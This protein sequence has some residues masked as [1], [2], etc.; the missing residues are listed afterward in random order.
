MQIECPYCEHPVEAPAGRTAIVC[1]GCGRRFV[2]CADP[3][4]PDRD[5]VRDADLS[6]APTLSRPQVQFTCPRCDREMSLPAGG[7]YGN[8]PNCGT[9]LDEKPPDA[10]PTIVTEPDA[11]PTVQTPRAAGGP[12][13]AEGRPSHPRGDEEEPERACEHDVEWLREHLGGRYEIVEFLARGGMGAVYRARQKRPRRDVALKM[14]AGGS[15]ASPRQRKRFEREA[16]AVAQLHH[17]A[18]VP[19]YEYGEIA[20]HPYFTMEYVEGVNLRDYVRRLKPDPKEICRLMVEVCEAIHYAHECGVIHRDLKP[21]NIIVEPSG[22]PRVLDFGLSRSSVRGEQSLLTATGDF[23]GTP[24]YMS[25][26]QAL[27]QPSKVDR[28]SDVYALGIILYELLTGM[29]PYPVDHVQGLEVYQL[30][31]EADPIPPRDVNPNMPRDLEVIILTAIAKEK[32]RRYR[33]VRAL[34]RDLERFLEDRP[35]LARPATWWY[36]LRKWAWRNRAALTPVAISAFVLAAVATVLLYQ[37]ASESRRADRLMKHY[38]RIM[39]GASNTREKVGQLIAEDKWDEARWLGRFAAEIMPHEAGVEGLAWRVRRAAEQ[40]MQQALAEFTHLLSR[41]RWR[42]AREKARELT[43]LAETISAYPELA[44]RL[45]RVEPEFDRRC[46]EYLRETVEQAY[47]QEPADRALRSFIEQLPGN[48][49]VESARQLLERLRSRQPQYFFEQHAAAFRRAMDACR[50][51]EA[52]AVCVSGERF[53]EAEDLSSPQLARATVRAWRRELASVIRPATARALAPLQSARS[54]TTP[55]KDIAVA[56]QGLSFVV[57]RIDRPLEL[58]SLRD[59]AS[60]ATLS[61]PARARRVAVSPAGDLLAAYLENG[62]IPL[63]S[64]PSRKKLG[65]LRGHASRVPSLAFSSDGTLLL[66]ADSRQ[67]TLW[68]V[69]AGKRLEEQP[70]GASAPAGFAPD[71]ELVAAALSEASIGLWEARTGRLVLAMPAPSTPARMVFSPTADQLLSAHFMDGQ[72]SISTWNINT[73]TATRLTSLSGRVWAMAVSPD[74]RL[75]VTGDT[76]PSLKLWAVD[77]GRRLVRARCGSLPYTAAFDPRCRDLLVGHN[78]GTVSRWG[79][80]P[81]AEADGGRP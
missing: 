69:P 24:R 34:A 6:E 49:H 22:R 61:V 26:E 15:L 1:P 67:V 64:L 20:G 76:E 38:E 8:C 46:W 9:S 36:R 56:G 47:R 66:S 78:D 44:D 72:T 39:A 18:I 30:I 41:H 55:V 50:W 71:G 74:G 65:A 53:V 7:P 29:T 80:P 25:P 54:D 40:R 75:V 33:T 27:G 73:G 79:I 3:S 59:W 37:V 28:R 13:A 16:Q 57:A 14:L 23:L 52:E 42:E 5:S 4:T 32:D 43:R 17:P 70:K 35:I 2:A 58:W 63:W 10:Q 68:E 62:Q 51:E 19:I 12:A 45:A 77:D 48:P 81:G 21:G 60:T 11:R 31:C